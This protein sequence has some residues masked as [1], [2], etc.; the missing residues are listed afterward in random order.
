MRSRWLVLWALACVAGALDASWTQYSDRASL[1]R[2]KVWRDTMRARLEGVAVE[3]LSPTDRRAV[4]RLRAMLQEEE[5][6]APEA[7]PGWGTAAMGAAVLV[8]VAA[9]LARLRGR[10]GAALGGGRRLSAA[11]ERAARLRAVE[12]RQ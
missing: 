2:S 9:V 10:A 7:E 4:E 12:K 8:A 1:P 6:W 11:A 3:G 5:G